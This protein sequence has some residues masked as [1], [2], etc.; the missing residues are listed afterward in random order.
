MKNPTII[1]DKAVRKLCKWALLYADFRS[2]LDTTVLFD[3][4]RKRRVCA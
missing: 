4:N 3:R 2:I 1:R